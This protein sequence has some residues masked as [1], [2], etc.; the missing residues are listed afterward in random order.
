[1]FNWASFD[2]IALRVALVVNI[3]SERPV[4]TYADIL[5]MKR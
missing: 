2:E 1:M 5:T 4:R 3:I